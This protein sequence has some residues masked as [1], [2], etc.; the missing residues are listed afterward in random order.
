M[1]LVLIKEI[2]SATSPRKT[3][4]VRLIFDLNQSGAFLPA[5]WNLRSGNNS[6]IRFQTLSKN[7]SIPSWFGAQSSEPKWKSEGNGKIGAEGIPVTDN[8]NISIADNPQEMIDSIAKIF[9]NDSFYKQIGNNALNFVRKHFDNN[10]LAKQLSDF[11]I[12]NLQID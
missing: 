11:Y 7:H 8:Y 2:A 4:F 1:A 3:T 12:S 9:Q 10:K 5:I 6:L